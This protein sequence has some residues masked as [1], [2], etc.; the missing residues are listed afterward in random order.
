MKKKTCQLQIVRPI[1]QPS[2]FEVVSNRLP[3]RDIPISSIN[4]IISL[5]QYKKYY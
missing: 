4:V 1:L 2:G 3:L 5:N